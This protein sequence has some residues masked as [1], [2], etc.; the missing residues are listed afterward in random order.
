MNAWGIVNVK[1]L[2]YFEMLGRIFIVFDNSKF[3]KIYNRNFFGGVNLFFFFFGI[4][5]FYIGIFLDDYKF[6]KM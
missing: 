1:F 6:R 4:Y 2:G 3:R 5:Y